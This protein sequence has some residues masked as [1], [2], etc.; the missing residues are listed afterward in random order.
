MSRFLLCSPGQT[1]STADLFDGLKVAL[2]DAGHGVGTYALTQRIQ[3]AQECLMLRY[4]HSQES[5]PQLAEPTFED[6]LYHASQELLAAALRYDVDWVLFI[7][8]GL[9]PPEV[10]VLLRKAGLRTAVLFTESPYEDKRQSDLAPLLNVCF[11]NERTSV[12]SLRD[13]NPH[14]YYLR[15][16]YDPAR[17]YPI[18]SEE[19]TEVPA[20]DVLFIGTLWQERIDLLT[21]VDWTGID[22]ALYGEQKWLPE[23]H[24]LWQYVRGEHVANARAA[25]MYRRA[26]VNLNLY[27]ESAFYTPDAPRVRTAESVNPRA[28]EL[29]ACGAFQLAQPRAEQDELLGT[30]AVPTFRTA[31][32]L[33]AL[34]RRSLTDP[35]W[36]ATAANVARQR[37]EG[38]TFAARAAEIVAILAPLQSRK[39]DTH[40]SPTSRQKRRD[41]HVNGR[42]RRADEARVAS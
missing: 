9:V 32:E 1:H 5:L 36:R 39:G 25:E 27:R 28:L 37:V 40:G 17:H 35:I 31:E 41:P 15:H 26:K 16:A 30:D 23:G 19:R 8:S 7:S 38:Q 33:Q 20:H 4:Q 6:V 24:P 42:G 13:M 11:T 12:V 34:L 29:A 18:V 22:L 14:T 2:Y 10:Y 21:A 3:H